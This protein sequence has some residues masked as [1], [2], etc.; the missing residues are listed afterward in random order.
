MGSVVGTV[1]RM[2]SQ[3]PYLESLAFRISRSYLLLFGS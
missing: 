1:G 2:P 3:L